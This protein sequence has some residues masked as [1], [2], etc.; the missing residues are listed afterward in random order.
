MHWRCSSDHY[1]QAMIMKWM[2]LRNETYVSPLTGTFAAYILGAVSGSVAVGSR[3][4]GLNRLRTQLR[5]LCGCGISSIA[6]TIKRIES[7]SLH[8]SYDPQCVINTRRD[9]GAYR[10]I[11][12]Y[13]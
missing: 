5:T 4:R 8:Y 11:I 2:P 13:R 7:D 1:Q 12:R 6:R 3:R 9:C 10:S